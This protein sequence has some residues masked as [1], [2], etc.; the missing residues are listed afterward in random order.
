MCPNGCLQLLCHHIPPPTKAATQ[1][2]PLQPAVLQQT[3]AM[4]DLKTILTPKCICSLVVAAVIVVSVVIT[5]LVIFSK[6]ETT[7]FTGPVSAPGSSFG[8]HSYT[9]AALNLQLDHLAFK[10]S[11]I[12]WCSIGALVLI[13]AILVYYYFKHR[14]HSQEISNI[15]RR[16]GLTDP[17][18]PPPRADMIYQGAPLTRGADHVGYNLPLPQNLAL[19]H[20]NNMVPNPTHFANNVSAYTAL[21]EDIEWKRMPP[22]APT[23]EKLPILDEL[24]NILN[25]DDLR[26]FPTA[27]PLHKAFLTSDLMFVTGYLIQ[28]LRPESPRVVPADLKDFLSLLGP[29][30]FDPDYEA[31]N[32]PRNCRTSSLVFTTGLEGV[33]TI[34]ASLTPQTA[35][36]CTHPRLMALHAANLAVYGVTTD[37]SP[38]T[39]PSHR[40]PKAHFPPCT[41]F[42]KFMSNP[43][44]QL[45]FED[46]ARQC[47]S[48]LSSI[49]HIDLSTF[50]ASIATSKDETSEA[51]TAHMAVLQLHSPSSGRYR[52]REWGIDPPRHHG[53]K[54]RRR[55]QQQFPLNNEWDAFHSDDASASPVDP[56][57]SGRSTPDFPDSGRTT[58]NNPIPCP[59]PETPRKPKK[60]RVQEVR[61]AISLS[62][63][64]DSFVP[65]PRQARAF[66][67]TGP[68][69]QVVVSQQAIDHIVDQAA[70]A[71]F[72]SLAHKD[73]PAYHAPGSGLPG[74]TQ[75]CPRQG[76]NV[77]GMAG[78]TLDPQMAK[79]EPT[80]SPSAF[81]GSHTP[82]FPPPAYYMGPGLSDSPPTRRIP[83][84][85]GQWSPRT[86]PP[87]P[88]VQAAS[89]PPLV[90]RPREEGTPQEVGNPPRAGRA[91]GG[92]RG[93]SGIRV[94]LMTPLSC[95]RCCIVWGHEKC[96][97]AVGSEA[98]PCGCFDP[99]PLEAVRQ[100][101]ETLHYTVLQDK[102]IVGKQDPDSPILGFPFP[103]PVGVR[104]TTASTS[105][106]WPPLPYGGV[107]MMGPPDPALFPGCEALPR[108]T[109]E[110]LHLFT[111]RI[112]SFSPCVLFSDNRMSRSRRDWLVSLGYPPLQGADEM[113]KRVL[114]LIYE[115]AKSRL[116]V[117]LSEYDRWMQSHTSHPSVSLDS[118]LGKMLAAGLLPSLDEALTSPSYPFLP[119]DEVESEWE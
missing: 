55:K 81:F 62:Y 52:F 10:S 35:V 66:P 41:N 8:A 43:T 63:L 59:I 65:E 80:G 90:D 105:A 79:V 58:P 40:T 111:Q 101:K 7:D 5:S 30:E 24:T 68:W 117:S 38:D 109:G 11:T 21:L 72:T 93:S 12:I 16:S 82:P 56:P 28:V 27:L 9:I 14:S 29:E 37:L 70:G 49:C 32:G 112:D 25:A 1:L 102:G 46:V 114:L 95:P 83:A 104:V 94:P 98:P 60:S 15:K 47:R 39:L 20:H 36:E 34:K 89:P 119:S 99:N 2:L 103:H 31:D 64:P 19:L 61:D 75:P 77:S 51:V 26:L 50:L 23:S 87:P 108:A 91:I 42:S 18:P 110:P 97:T 78:P 3:S 76:H 115:A 4:A 118:R 106:F 96:K 107:M 48:I 92:G 116:Q 67:G 54:L 113:P 13:G 22:T 74:D 100:V 33:T 73:P 57:S 85:R 84:E 17:P 71:E 6:G 45:P 53:P 44:G 88:P 69:L 86:R